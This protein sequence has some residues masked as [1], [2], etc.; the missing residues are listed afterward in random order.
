MLAFITSLPSIVTDTPEQQYWTES[1]LHRY[2]RL[3][4]RHV[5]D[6]SRSPSKSAVPPTTVLAP[7][8]AYAKYWDARRKSNASTIFKDGKQHGSSTHTWASYY[9]TLSILLQRGTTEHSFDSKFQQGIELKKVEA[10]YESVLLKETKFPKANQANA[11]IESWVD[12]VTANWRVMCGHTWQDEDLSEGGK[13]T[14]G[15][16]VLDVGCFL[17]IQLFSSFHDHSE[18]RRKRGLTVNLTDPL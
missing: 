14:L 4:S 15:R 6:K 9:D 18:L 7:F 3:S 5:L 12:Q 13:A 1:L 17:D 10:A 16:G 2:C 11:H 8:R